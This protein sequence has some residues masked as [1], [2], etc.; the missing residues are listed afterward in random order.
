M[1][2]VQQI[3]NH[4]TLPSIFVIPTSI[5]VSLMFVIDMQ[6]FSIFMIHVFTISRHLRFP[7]LNTKK[8]TILF[9][10][11]ALTYD[12]ASEPADF[13]NMAGLEK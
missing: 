4:L 8:F 10:L 7:S 13:N 5:S 3:Q 11:T 9:N 1:K 2:V 12:S 6:L